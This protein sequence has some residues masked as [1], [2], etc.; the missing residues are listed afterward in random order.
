MRMPMCVNFVITEEAFVAISLFDVRS[1][2]NGNL[3]FFVVIMLNW[4]VRF[5]I[6]KLCKICWPEWLAC[7]VTELSVHY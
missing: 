3:S 2:V 4:A 5:K 6:C 1:N 7:A